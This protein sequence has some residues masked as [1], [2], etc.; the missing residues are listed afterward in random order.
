MYLHVVGECK[1]T[2]LPLPKRFS[3]FLSTL[4]RD[5]KGRKTLDE[6]C[7][8]FERNCV[9]IRYP[10]HS[11]VN[12]MFKTLTFPFNHIDHLTGKF[13]DEGLKRETSASESL[14]LR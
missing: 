9:E 12:N 8:T 10:R 5:F 13:S 7:A 1:G 2:E 11:F 14:I 6:A 4:K 3:S